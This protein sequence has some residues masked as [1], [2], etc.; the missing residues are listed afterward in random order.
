VTYKWSDNVVRTRVSTWRLEYLRENQIAELGKRFDEQAA[1]VMLARMVS[2]KT[3][4][5][6]TLEVKKWVDRL[7]LKFSV[8]F[9]FFNRNDKGSF[10]LP[11]ALKHFPQFIYHLRRS[12]FINPFGSPPDQSI[13]VKTCMQRESVP[14]CMVM[15]QPALLSYSPGESEPVPV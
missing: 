13:Y 5:E 12:A 10:R 14:N 1:A 6:D 9:A 7:L 11:P 4:V 15:I 8:R 2:R 3:E